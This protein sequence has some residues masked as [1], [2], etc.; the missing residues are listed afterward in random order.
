MRMEYSN[1]DLNMDAVHTQLMMDD[2]GDGLF[3][4]ASSDDG[5]HGVYQ[6]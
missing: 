5:R 2:I 1:V 6:R 4:E 3:I